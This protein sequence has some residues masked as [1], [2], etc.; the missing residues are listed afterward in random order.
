MIDQPKSEPTPEELAAS[1]SAREDR[2]GATQNSLQRESD[3]LFRLYGAYSSM[4]TKAPGASPGASLLSSPLL[5][6]R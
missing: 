3:R 1:A 2:R 4:F 6:R 5:G